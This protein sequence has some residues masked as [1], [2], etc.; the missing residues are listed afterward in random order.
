HYPLKATYINLNNQ[1]TITTT[2]TYENCDNG[3]SS[4]AG[5]FNEKITPKNTNG[6][7]RN[8]PYFKLP[9]KNEIEK[10]RKMKLS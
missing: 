2:F 4:E 9:F 10:F 3:I 8:K 1:G 6:V 5:H 7:K